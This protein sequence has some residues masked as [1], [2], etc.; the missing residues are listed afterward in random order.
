VDQTEIRVRLTAG[1]SPQPANRRI[2]VECGKGRRSGMLTLAVEKAE[3]QPHDESVAD[4]AVEEPGEEPTSAAHGEA[5]RINSLEPPTVTAGEPLTLTVMGVN[6][7]EGA[8]VEVFANANAGTSREPDYR[9]VP[10]PVEVASDT[11]L[12]VDFDRGFAPS[13]KQRSVTVVNADGT[14]SPPLF[15]GITRSLP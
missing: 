4:A 6:F 9:A 5:P 13:P 15:L 1:L 12:L 2:V 10:F 11:V 14:R 8:T 7:R 3:P